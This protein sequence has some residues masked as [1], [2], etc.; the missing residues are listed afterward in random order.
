MTYL[1]SIRGHSALPEPEEE[2]YAASPPEFQRCH[3]RIDAAH[4]I[5]HHYPEGFFQCSCKTPTP[6]KEAWAEHLAKILFP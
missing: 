4:V 5:A 6:T 3:K 2:H 1:S